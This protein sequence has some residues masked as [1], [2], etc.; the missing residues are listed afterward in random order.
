VEEPKVSER[1]IQLI[2]RSE[3]ILPATTPCRMGSVSVSV[4]GAQQ[5]FGSCCKC[6]CS[7]E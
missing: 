1:R 3:V 2:G 5:V 7:A 4:S 6:V